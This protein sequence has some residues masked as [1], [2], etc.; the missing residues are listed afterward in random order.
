MPTVLIRN[1]HRPIGVRPE[2]SRIAC[3]IVNGLDGEVVSVLDVQPVEAN[4]TGDVAVR[5]ASVEIAMRP[6]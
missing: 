2:L 4:P 6:R 5:P 3:D 1:L